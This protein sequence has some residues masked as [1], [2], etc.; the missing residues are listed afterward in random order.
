MVALVSDFIFISVAPSP[1]QNVSINAPSSIN[2]LT[3]GVSSS[4][5]VGLGS[6]SLSNVTGDKNTVIGYQAS[7]NLTLSSRVNISLSLYD[8]PN[9]NK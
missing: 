1:S 4:E 7:K 8:Q 2:D 6:Y 3:D 9:L 5:N